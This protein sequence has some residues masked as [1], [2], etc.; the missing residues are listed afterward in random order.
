MLTIKSNWRTRRV[1]P[2]VACRYT[3][4]RAAWLRITP[5]TRF[6]FQATARA[7]SRWPRQF[8]AISKRQINTA[9]FLGVGYPTLNNFNEYT[10]RVDYNLNDHN[11]ISGRSFDNFFS[12]PSYSGGNAVASNRSWIVDWQSYAGTWTWTISPQHGQQCDRFLHSHV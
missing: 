1:I 4:C 11:R 8:R 2:K 5:A 10:A 9:Q 3:N 12:Q 7:R 6:Q